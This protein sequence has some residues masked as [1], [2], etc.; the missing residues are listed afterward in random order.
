M[1]AHCEDCGYE[2]RNYEVEEDI[3][4]ATRQVLGQVC[5]DGGYIT[6]NKQGGNYSKCPE[7]EQDTLVIY[8]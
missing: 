5:L 6:S 8:D 2:S 1:F 3:E 7:C 4:A